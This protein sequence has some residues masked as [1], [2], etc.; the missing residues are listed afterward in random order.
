MKVI[1]ITGGIA[2][3]KTTVL[4]FLKELGAQC[5]DADEISRS[6]TAPGGE[7][8]P[9]LREA[10]TDAVFCAD[11]TLNRRALGALVFANE[12]KRRLLNALLHPLIRQK[13]QLALDGLRL[14]GER[15]A[16]LDV[17]LLFESGMQDMACEVWLVAAPEKVQ[18]QRL[19]DRDGYTKEEALARIRSQMP[20]AEKIRLADRVIQTDGSLDDLRAKVFALWK[21]ETQRGCPPPEKKE[22][23]QL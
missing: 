3:G 11:G 8:L 14:Q 1:A 7:A 16:V 6:L 4:G 12:Q 5:V 22:E 2:S 9:L 10:F 15:I 17:P 21:E 19:M 20:L 18:L 23:T 13:M